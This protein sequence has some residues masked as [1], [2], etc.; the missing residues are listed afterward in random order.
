MTINVLV[1]CPA[2]ALGEPVKKPVRKAPVL[3]SE[4]GLAGGHALNNE[5]KTKY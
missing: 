3:Y 4:Q 2:T 1:N 5:E